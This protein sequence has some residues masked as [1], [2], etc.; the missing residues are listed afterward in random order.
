MGNK[1][2]YDKLTDKELKRAVKDLINNKNYKPDNFTNKIKSIVQ[3]NYFSPN[4]RKFIINH[5]YHH[6]RDF[7]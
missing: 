6:S 2:L 3:L 7:I 4:Q 1:S 5:I